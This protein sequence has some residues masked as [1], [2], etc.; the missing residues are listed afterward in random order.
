MVWACW[1]V[2]PWPAR[3]ARARLS[4]VRW[5]AWICHAVMIF[6]A[7]LP[8]FRR[9]QASEQ[10]MKGACPNSLRISFAALNHKERRLEAGGRRKEKGGRR[11]EDGGGRGGSR[12]QGNT[13]GPPTVRQRVQFTASVGR[14]KGQGC[15]YCGGPYLRRECWILN[16][17]LRERPCFYHT[18]F[19]KFRR[20]RRDVENTHDPRA[21]GMELS[22]VSARDSCSKATTAETDGAGPRCCPS[23]CREL[24]QARFP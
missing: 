2:A 14:R 8:L 3:A 9:F 7:A 22:V 10:I 24:P 17:Q 15:N 16:W 20:Y 11:R 12:G 19:D 13:L 18:Y 21:H 23:P 4:C 5:H 6:T 1:L